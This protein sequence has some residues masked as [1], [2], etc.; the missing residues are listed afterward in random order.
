M[1]TYRT[2]L[3]YNSDGILAEVHSGSIEN[4]PLCKKRQIENETDKVREQTRSRVSRF[5][6]RLRKDKQEQATKDQKNKE[7]KRTSILQTLKNIPTEAKKRI[8]SVT[9]P[10]SIKPTQ[11]LNKYSGHCIYCGRLL[12]PKDANQQSRTGIC[13]EFCGRYK[14]TC[15]EE[16]TFLEHFIAHLP[17][18][19]GRI[20]GR[21]PIYNQGMK[22]WTLTSGQL[23][24][25]KQ[26]RQD[27]KCKCHRA[28][29]PYWLT[30]CPKCGKQRGD[31]Q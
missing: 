3:G 11:D 31:K 8:H 23:E 20:T 19:Q 25:L 7:Q 30:T 9:G 22:T 28:K 5:R 26:V 2:H 18:I 1:T 14:I 4:C 12:L 27:W 29:I 10:W 24:L 6:D 16:A 13:K 21:E 15:K 17:Y